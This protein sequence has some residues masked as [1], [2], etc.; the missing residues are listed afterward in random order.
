MSIYGVTKASNLE[1]FGLIESFLKKSR[2]N[3]YDG[4]GK[5]TMDL[6]EFFGSKGIKEIESDVVVALLSPLYDEYCN[7]ALPCIDKV[8]TAYKKNGD[9]TSTTKTSNEE[10][11]RLLSGEVYTILEGIE[12]LRC[13]KDSAEQKTPDVQGQPIGV[14]DYEHLIDTGA[15][16][17]IARL[18]M[19]NGKITDLST[20]KQ[21]QREIRDAVKKRIVE[22][23]NFT[24]DFMLNK[25]KDS[26]LEINKQTMDTSKEERT[27][28][29]FSDLVSGGPKPVPYEQGLED[30]KQNYIQQGTSET[31]KDVYGDVINDVKTFGD[32]RNLVQQ[33]LVSGE[34]KPVSYEQ[35]LEGTKQNYIQQGTPETLK[36]V[37]GDAINDVKTFG[38]LRNLVQ[39]GLVSGE[40]KPVSYETGLN[41][42]KDNFI[43]GPVA[44][45]GTA[46][47]GMGASVGAE[48]AGMAATTAAGISSN[49]EAAAGTAAMGAG[50]VAGAGAAGMAAA[51]AAC[52]SPNPEPQGL[53]TAEL[54]LQEVLS[55]RN[56]ESPSFALRFWRFRLLARGLVRESAQPCGRFPRR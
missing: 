5:V 26:I 10:K 24:V 40:P 30:V 2:E 15:E 20:K 28:A 13:Q 49:L 37:Y 45:A 31:L 35:G 44:S 11:D 12:S 42:L 17:L 32:L 34:P 6:R 21:V 53:S 51:T 54:L 7:K 52:I 48:A 43:K 46:A 39:Q 55:Q 3:F 47:M 25:T 41:E 36:D 27:S 16:N 22:A 33:G 18:E 4:F 50:A 29:D 23:A 1:L 56:R 9:T 19:L 8:L 14:P 38:D